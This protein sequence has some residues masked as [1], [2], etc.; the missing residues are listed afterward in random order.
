MEKEDLINKIIEIDKEAK[1]QICKEKE[2]N[3]NIKEYVS[4]EFAQKKE[5]IDEEYHFKLELEKKKFAE[6]FL[7]EK[8]KIDSKIV[9]ELEEVADRYKKNENKIIEENFEIIKSGE[10]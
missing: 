6:R 10:E 7:E 2:K 1:E 3:N 5:E 8:K 9:K 4:K